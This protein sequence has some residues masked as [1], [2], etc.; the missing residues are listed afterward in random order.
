[1]YIANVYFTKEIEKI[2]YNH[3]LIGE[4]SLNYEEKFTIKFNDTEELKEKLADFITSGFRVWHNDF[5]EY[6]TN[7]IENNRF[8]YAQIEDEDN[9]K[10][11]L[12]EENPN[13]YMCDYTFIV[14]SVSQEIEYKF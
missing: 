10:I 8:D 3:D 6:V 5:I 4:R 13:G 12:S 7:E 14:T 1:M 9:N 11:D 2:N